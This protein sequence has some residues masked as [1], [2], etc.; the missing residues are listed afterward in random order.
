VVTEL[1][2]ELY[3]LLVDQVSEVVTLNLADMECNPPTLPPIWAEHSHGIY[4][5]G[6][7]LLV[8]LDVAKLLRLDIGLAA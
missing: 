8:V 2:S 4:R 1:G 7:R 5:V 3:A 6:K